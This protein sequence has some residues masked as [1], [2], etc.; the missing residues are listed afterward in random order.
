MM[1]QHG[2]GK[3]LVNLGKVGVSYPLD[4]GPIDQDRDAYMV[5]KFQQR[6][7]SQLRAVDQ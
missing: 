5:G 4:W 2:T 6:I 3:Y 7:I 1:W